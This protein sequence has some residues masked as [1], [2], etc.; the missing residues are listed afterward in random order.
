M[1]TPRNAITRNGLPTGIMLRLCQQYNG[2]LSEYMEL[3]RLID[4]TINIIGVDAVRDSLEWMTAND[5]TGDRLYSIYVK[6][7]GSDLAIFARMV[8]LVCKE[9][10]NGTDYIMDRYDDAYSMMVYL[11]HQAKYMP[12]A[13]TND[14]LLAEILKVI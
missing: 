2:R 10:S 13:R 7:C 14:E 8:E 9:S 1:N 5:I 3:R 12:R 11:T 6:H 4:A